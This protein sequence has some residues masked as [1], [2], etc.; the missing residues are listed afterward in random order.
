LDKIKEYKAKNRFYKARTYILEKLKITHKIEEVIYLKQQLALCYYKDN[1][2]NY[3]ISF[4]KALVILDDSEQLI[5]QN[6]TIVNYEKIIS[7]NLS[8][9][10][11]VYKRYFEK[12]KR[13]KDLKKSIEYYEEVYQKYK[14]I[15]NGYAGINTANLY[16]LLWYELNKIGINTDFSN[17]ANEIRKDLLD[18]IQLN[19]YWDY[20][21]MANVYLGLKDT[22]KCN[23]ILK[24][25]ILKYDISEWEKFT[26]FKDLKKIAQINNIDDL[27]FLTP[28]FD[29]VN[30]DFQK[31]GLALSG[32]GFRASLFHI[33]V[34]SA[35]AE[36]DKLKDIDVISTVSGGSIVGVLYY[37]KLKQLLETKEDKDITQDDYLQLI[38]ELIDEFFEAVQQDI[39]NKIF[40]TLNPK[41]WLPFG[42]Y[43]RTKRVA[44]FYDEYFYK[45]YNIK[46]LRELKIIP[47]NFTDFYPRFENFKRMNKVPIL[48]INATNLNNGHNFQFQATK[49]GE[50]DLIGEYD[51]NFLVEWLRFDECEKI[52]DFKLSEAVCASTAVPGIFPPLVLELSDEIKLN[53]ADGGVYDNQ[54]INALLMEECNDI[55]TSDGGYEMDDMKKIGWF[56]NFPKTIGIVKYIKRSIDILMDVNRDLLYEKLEYISNTKNIVLNSKNSVDKVN[57]NSSVN[58]LSNVY[59]K[60]S[61]IRTDLNKFTKDEAGLLMAFGYSLTKEN[62][63]L[64]KENSFWFKAYFNKLGLDK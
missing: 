8:L 45:K 49:I 6:K 25:A 41:F 10:G 14:E 28:L 38:S 30:I 22:Q 35:L 24:E 61:K 27:S 21:S 37:L 16:E 46:Y 36:A 32:G 12:D 59:E 3:K 13:I 19:H 63:E 17:R 40:K 56:Y 33:G 51:R 34:L 48:V 57:C 4:K 11:A 47:K 53:L 7:E 58:S 26:I 31:T 50:N 55:I 64:K 62:L 23:D 15:D 39:R 60:I 2:V 52:K 20:F 5:L 54:G 9:M 42:S 29:N 43:T 1:E 44:E 18:T